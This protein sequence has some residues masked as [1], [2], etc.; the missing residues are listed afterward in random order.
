MMRKK[1]ARPMLDT[2][3]PDGLPAST[4]SPLPPR[5]PDPPGRDGP[6]CPLRCCGARAALSGQ[7]S[8]E[9]VSRLREP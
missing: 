2:L 5:C 6:L 7:L 9:E 3:A 1:G 8:G 4:R